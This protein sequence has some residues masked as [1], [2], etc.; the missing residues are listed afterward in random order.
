MYFYAQISWRGNLMHFMWDR[1]DAEHRLSKN[2]ASIRLV[3]VF[4]M[5]GI[6]EIYS[7][8]LVIA[9]HKPRSS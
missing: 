3:F 2:T 6:V 4:I 1:L 9:F 7:S 5:A 8:V